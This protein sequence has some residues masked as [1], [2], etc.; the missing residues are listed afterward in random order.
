M[1]GQNRG[2]LPHLFVTNTATTEPYTTPIS[3]RGPT[4]NFPPRNRQQHAQS[5][6]QKLDAVKTVAQERDA[7]RTAF[8]IDGHGGICLEFES[9]ADFDLK[10]E[11]LEKASSGIELLGVKEVDSKKIATVFVPDGKLEQFEKRSSTTVNRKH[12]QVNRRISR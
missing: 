10:F 4:L 12:P 5:L 1:N 3:G 8:G 2:D 11:S 7:E 9:S 6:L